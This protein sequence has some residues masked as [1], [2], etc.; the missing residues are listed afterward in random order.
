MLVDYPCLLPHAVIHWALGIG[1][2]HWNDVV[3][4]V[5]RHKSMLTLYDRQ[6]LYAIRLQAPEHDFDLY[7]MVMAVVSIK[8]SSTH[9]LECPVGT[10]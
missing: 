4:T 8:V 9:S 10:F 6:M 7:F 5:R 3:D 1:K 2:V